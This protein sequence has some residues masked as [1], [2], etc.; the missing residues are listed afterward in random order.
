MA[1]IGI[2]VSKPGIDVSETD[3]KN[4]VINSEH[5]SLKVWMTG[6]TNIT[7]SAGTG[8]FSV[9]IAHGLGYPP[10]FLTYFKLVHASKY[11][12]QE[13]LDDSILPVDFV[14]GLAKADSTNLTLT[15]RDN[16]GVDA[17]TAVAYYIILIDKAYE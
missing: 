9:N 1:D 4:Q 11:W 10:F 7:K 17:F 14:Y 5:N 3:V 16:S 8:D 2:K 15:V 6:S 12:F 13:S